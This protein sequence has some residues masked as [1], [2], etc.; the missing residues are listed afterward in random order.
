MITT[1]TSSIYFNA[2]IA[3]QRYCQVGR[4][5]ATGSDDS[6]S[7]IAR[8]LCF[9]FRSS[10]VAVASVAELLITNRAC[11]QQ[12]ASHRR[13][14]MAISWRPLKASSIHMTGIF[15]VICSTR[16]WK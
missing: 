15:E 4:C 5:R 10:A 14:R 8:Y 7:S 12:Q 1:L 9:P 13:K 16:G 2:P 11:S 6:Y 3:K